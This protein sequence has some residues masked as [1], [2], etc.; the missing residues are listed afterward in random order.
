MIYG[1][2]D[3][4]RSAHAV[5]RMCRVLGVRRSGYYAWKKRAQSARKRRDAVLLGKIRESYRLSRGRYGSPNIHE[6][7]REWGYRCGR[8]RVARLM[9]EAG[10]RSKSV[11]RFR[12]TTQSKHTLPVAENL[13][14]RDFTAPAANRVWVSDIT[15]VWTQQGWMY[16]CIILDLWD[17]K[18]VGWSMG[19]RLMAELAIGALLKAVQL[20]RPSEGLI[21]HSDR[22]VQYASEGFKAEIHRYGMLQ[23]MSRKA[24][25]WDNA[26][27][28]SFFA[29]LKR[30]LVY[31]ETYRTRQEARLSVFEYIEG[32]YNRRRRHSTLGRRSPLEFEQAAMTA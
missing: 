15:Y 23:S 30:E 2:I 6:D 24:D 16:L 8:K 4:H 28:E 12:V 14:Q 25:C 18:V 32:W 5:E 13:L 1:F 11:R 17:R 29:I 21:F 26:V 10:I 7:L 3:K 22:G 27:A 19:K 9:R 31:H 20:R